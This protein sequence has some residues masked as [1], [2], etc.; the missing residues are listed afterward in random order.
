M[1]TAAKSEPVRHERVIPFT[2]A[3]GVECNVINVRGA[4][5][6]A[7][8]PVLL[9]HG[10]GVR[11]NIFR[12]PSGRT[13]VDA[14]I[15]ESH[16][17]WLENW[18][19]SIDV[20]HNAWTLDQAAVLDHP[21]AVKTVLS[22][23]GARE[24]KAV[25]HCQGSTS[26]MM[27]SVAGL[28][29]EVT[30]IVS[31][32]VSLHPVVT[33]PARRKLRYFV[34]VLARLLGYINPQWGMS[35]APWIA[36]KVMTAFVKLTHRECDNAVCK[37]A[38]YTY[39]SG[40]PTLWRHENLNAATHDWLSHE[41]ADVPLTFFRQMLRCVDAGRLLSVEE[42][43]ELPADLTAQPA[44]TDARFAF[45]AGDRNVCFLPLSQRRTFEWFDRQAPGR[46]RMHVLPGYGHLDVFMGKDAARDVF[47]TIV[48]ELQR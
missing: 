26:F 25:I 39:G 3:D 45:L 2:T 24:L 10:A 46:H 8:S 18:R 29:P 12:A 41:F 22:D 42:R 44:R 4:Q 5:A 43:P 47:P 34:P 33:R 48:D 17:V 23:T 31:N 38:S 6:P 27:S 19:A 30:T 7:K 21:A 16:D 37:L 13:L 35:G 32:A 20:P 15:D 28:L 1:A 36:P 14:L 11:A 9:V 40:K